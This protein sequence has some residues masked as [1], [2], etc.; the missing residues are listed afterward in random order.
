MDGRNSR[1]GDVGPVQQKKQKVLDDDSSEEWARTC[2]AAALETNDVSTFSHFDPAIDPI[3]INNINL[4]KSPII[5]EIE[6]TTSH[7][8]LDATPIHTKPLSVTGTVNLTVP[9]Q[10][11]EISSSSTSFNLDKQ[12][13]AKKITNLC[14]LMNGS[15]TQFILQYGTKYQ[16]DLANDMSQRVKSCHAN[17]GINGQGVDSS[18]WPLIDHFGALKE[19]QNIAGNVLWLHAVKHAKARVEG[20]KLPLDALLFESVIRDI[21]KDEIQIASG[22]T[23]TSEEEWASGPGPLSKNVEAVATENNKFDADT[24]RTASRDEQRCSLIDFEMELKSIQYRLQD[25]ENTFK[26]DPG[27]E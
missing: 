10:T 9:M 14:A 6:S 13:K 26:H 8:H 11:A 12:R 20:C 2:G 15:I 19:L 17:T 3:H 27:F 25:Y 4:E 22:N 21:E 16:S 23:D 1:S 24:T 5:D 18:L 7:S